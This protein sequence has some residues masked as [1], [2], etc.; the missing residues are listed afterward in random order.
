MLGQNNDMNN[1]TTYYLIRHAEKIRINPIEANPDLNERGYLRAENWK[2]VFQHIPFNA[3]YA[4]YFTRTLK[5]VEP[6]AISDELEIQLY[7][8][9]KIDIHQ[10]KQDTQNKNVLIVGHSNSIPQFVNQLINQEKY[11]EIDDAEF[12]H[13][14]IVTIQGNK[15]TDQLL[16]VDF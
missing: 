8:P 12:S 14:Y 9:T 11:L 6:I 15:I 3:I 5:T 1:S 16:Y 10:F 13:L 7:H 2:K 4:T